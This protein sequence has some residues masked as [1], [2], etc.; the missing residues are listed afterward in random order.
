MNGVTVL[1]AGIA[2]FLLTAVSTRPLGR[3]ALRWGITDHP[4]GYKTHERPIPY[5]GGV[6]IMLGTIVP[7]AAVVGLDD[8]RVI[9]IVLAAAA[10]AFLGLVDDFSPLSLLIRLAVEVV[11]ATGV[12]VGG[13]QAS[14]TESWADG[15]LTVLWIVV[16]TNSFNLLDNMDGAL[17]AISA[18]GA[19]CLAGTAFVCAQPAA[20]VLL[21]TLALASL[22]F[23]PHNWAPA[24][25]FMGDSGSLFIGFVFACSSAL[26]VTGK[27]TGA[28][29]TGLLLS[30][31][32]A[33]VDTGVVLLSRQLAGRPLLQGGN[34]HMSHRLRRIGLGTRATAAVL[35]LMAALTGVLGLAT[36]LNWISPLTVAVAAVG[37]V[38]ILIG[39][40]QRV[41]VYSSDRARSRP[42][43]ILER[44]R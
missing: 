32:V 2:A 39:L 3:L 22:G 35:A 26:L 4:G 33:T 10:V 23:L 30:T 34:D 20:G 14:L 17:G 24:K 38:L 8:V 28:V 15:P 9:A 31:F 7:F 6:A 5:L 18:A 37:A 29:I 40:P 12:V 21:V 43:T 27:G 11:A 25:V 16:I 1:G 36:A 42:A 13:V 41:R 44:R 19:A